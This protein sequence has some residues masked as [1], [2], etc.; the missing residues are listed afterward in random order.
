VL[1]RYRAAFKLLIPTSLLAPHRSFLLSPF[2]P[3]P[4]SSE[5]PLLPPRAAPLFPAAGPFTDTP[6]LP[7]LLSPSSGPP[8]NQ[9]QI[10]IKRYHCTHRNFHHGNRSEWVGYNACEC[11]LS[12]RARARVCVC[13]CVRERER[14][15]VCVCFGPHLI[16]PACSLSLKP[17]SN[18][19]T[20][21]AQNLAADAVETVLIELFQT[22]GHRCEPSGAIGFRL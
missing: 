18:I 8:S 3:F 10:R 4:S 19:R 11:T 1:L 21:F 17:S 16:C 12:A 5:Q 7:L 14:V 15:C 20:P 2:P 6:T 9:I 22:S 13:V